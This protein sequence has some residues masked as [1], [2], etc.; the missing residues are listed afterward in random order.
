MQMNYNTKPFSAAVLHI[1]MVSVAKLR[2]KPVIRTTGLVNIPQ[3]VHLC[4]I[5]HGFQVADH[6]AL[7]GLC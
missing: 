4:N 1:C 5:L 2:M 7:Q 3:P 6:T